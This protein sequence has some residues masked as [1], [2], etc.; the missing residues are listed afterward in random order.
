LE[1]RRKK[2]KNEF[3][4]V[5]DLERDAKNEFEREKQEIKG[6]IDR[7]ELDSQAELRQIKNR[8]IDMDVELKR[9]KNDV[10]RVISL[11]EKE[12]SAA[13]E[14]QDD[15]SMEIRQIEQQRVTFRKEMQV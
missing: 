5:A 9:V 7:R 10:Q 15:M 14:K 8:A 12:I 3:N 1:L 4:E 6:D 2:L 13:Q 11:R